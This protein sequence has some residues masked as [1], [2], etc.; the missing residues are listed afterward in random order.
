MKLTAENYKGV[1]I[2]V[3]QK[4]IGNKPIVEASA[5]LKGRKL[6]AVAKT[7]ALVMPK[8]KEQIDKHMR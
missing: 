1:T 8:I 4:I 7:K 5:L 6:N 3:I 2:N